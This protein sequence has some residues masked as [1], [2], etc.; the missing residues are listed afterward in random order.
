MTRTEAAEGAANVIA[1][2]RDIPILGNK[3]PYDH[4]LDLLQDFVR[5]MA[6]D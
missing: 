3:E 6:R 4:L 5:I 2:L 1:T